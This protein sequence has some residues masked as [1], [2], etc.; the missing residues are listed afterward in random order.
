MLDLANMMDEIIIR[1]H[2]QP[3]QTSQFATAEVWQARYYA[4]EELS[5]VAFLV[6]CFSVLHIIY[7]VH[8]HNM[9]HL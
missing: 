6:A 3:Q 1:S 4:A 5:L 9:H 7:V 8:L 2:I